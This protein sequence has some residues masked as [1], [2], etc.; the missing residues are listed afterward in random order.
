M[1]SEKRS[2]R[3][4]TLNRVVP[5]LNTILSLS[6][7]SAKSCISTQQTQKSFSITAGL[8]PRRAAVSRKS[9]RRSV[10]VSRATLSMRHFLADL[11]DGGVDPPGSRP[12]VSEDFLAQLRIKPATNLRNDVRRNPILAGRF[13]SLDDQ[14][15]LGSFEAG[16]FQGSVLKDQRAVAN[17]V[18]PVGAIGQVNDSCGYLRREAQEVLC[19]GPTGLYTPPEFARH[20]L[21]RLVCIRAEFLIEQSAKARIEIGRA[22][23]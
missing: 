2:I 21:G 12:R 4:N 3:P 1:S 14:T 18:R 19:G 6:S 15:A 20:R 22:H 16:F 10:A 5:P 7:G 23:V 13:Q 11:L 17:P 9:S 8:I